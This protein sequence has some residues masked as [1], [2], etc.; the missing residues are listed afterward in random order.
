LSEG[1]DAV[2]DIGSIQVLLAGQHALLRQAI[3]SALENEPGMH[4]VGE[5]RMG[6]HAVTEAARVAPDV[7]VLEIDRRS[8][9]GMY[10]I[11]ALRR[12]IPDCRVL[13]LTDGE[14]PETLIDALDAGAQG[15]V[16]KESALADLVAALRAVVRGEVVIPPK[17]VTGIITT[18]IQRRK[19]RNEGATRVSRLTAREQEVLRLLS[20]GADNVAIGRAL[21]ISPQTARTHIQ[22]ILGKLG[23]HSRLEAVAI[24]RAS[25]I[26]DE[27]AMTKYL[28]HADQDELVIVERV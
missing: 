24:A 23:A 27:A 22:N 13:L 14:D 5:T 2:E 4:V 10:A 9:D 1:R 7:A 11:T 21:V 28:D 20:R 19:E 15:Y 16:S 17:M 8:P 6:V 3:H 26:F 18:L 12:Q 25:G